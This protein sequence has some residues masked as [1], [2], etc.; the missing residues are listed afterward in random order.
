MGHKPKTII[1]SDNKGAFIS[2]EIQKYLTED[3]VKHLT[4]LN[5]AAF[6][7]RAIRTIKHMIYKRVEHN[8][9]EWYDEMFPVLMT[10]NNKMVNRATKMTPR[11]AMK[12]NHSLSV[13]MNLEIHSKNNRKYTDLNI[14]DKV[15]KLKKKDK[16]DKERIS[17]W[18]A[19]TYTIK[20]IIQ[21]GNQDLYVL[22][23][24]SKPI[25]RAEL[26]KL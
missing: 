17:T 22:E 26:L 18:S 13:K 4:T 23:G 20:K 8:K 19:E 24:V 11:E 3:G 1:M 2:H 21:Y 7:E 6:A 5:H 15:K 9:T 10:Y 12:P 25:L 14:G 16:L